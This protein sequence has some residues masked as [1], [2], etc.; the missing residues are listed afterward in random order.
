MSTTLLDREA[1]APAGR[2]VI[3]SPL[4]RVT[5][6]TAVGGL[7]SDLLREQQT[8]TAA[9]R[10]ARVHDEGVPAQARYYRDLIPLARPAAGQQ[11]AFEVDLDACTGC[12][13][14]VAAC[15]S[16]NGLDETEMWR[17]VGVLHGGT[18]AEPAQQTVT[19]SCHHCLDP[20]C[21]SGCPVQAYEKD[22][23]TGI[24][25]HLDD[26]CIGCQYCTL[27]C[28]YDAPKYNARLGVVRKCDMCSGRLEAGEAPACV[29]GCPSGAIAI[30]I[31][32]RSHAIDEARAERFLPGAPTPALTTPTTVYK[33]SRPAP[34]A[35]IP[36]DAHAVVAQ[37]A[38]LP[39]GLLLVLTQLGAGTFA[40]SLLAQ[41][42]GLLPPVGPLPLAVSSLALGLTLVGLVASVFHLGRPLGAW[43]ALLGLRTSWMSREALA[44]GL[45][46][47]LA[48]LYLLSLAPA[49]WPVLG[50]LPGMSFVT[51]LRSPLAAGTTVVGLGGVFCSVM[52]YVATGRR[53]W[54]LGPVAVKFFGTSALL[55]MASLLLVIEMV[56]A[57]AGTDGHRG[58]PALVGGLLLALPLVTVF[59]LLI[60]LAPLRH[61][62]ARE[63]QGARQN[64][65]LLWGPL[66]SV[67]QLRLAL[68]VAGGV[69]LPMLAR[70]GGQLGPG[71]ALAIFLTLLTGELLERYLFF[72][73]APASR[74]P[75]PVR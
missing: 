32:E 68:A 22:P 20:A 56:G 21:L 61:L 43:R 28:P 53:H 55:G 58:G 16:L 35:M 13:A 49:Q 40:L 30:K 69:L 71:G 44:F 63:P 75:G 70:A 65:R 37:P 1:L 23:V 48:V 57:Q 11:Y 24:V 67:L 33:T 27:M 36:A 26:Q 41:Q 66:A 34:A 45:F 6:G 73:G 4:L 31:V 2:A 3:R 12:K 47:K 7:L 52:I 46:A 54:A 15:H 17:S 72:T 59:K 10:F 60:E 25:R 38:H 29:Q 18:A 62:R 19:S 5:Q 42:W 74:M 50:E 9:D 64:A 8:M 14:C 51:A 39:L